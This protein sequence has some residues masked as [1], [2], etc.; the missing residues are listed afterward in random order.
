MCFILPFLLSFASPA[1]P[2][3]VVKPDLLNKT[4]MHLP[5]TY[6]SSQIDMTFLSNQT[7]DKLAD[8]IN[9]NTNVISSIAEL[10]QINSQLVMSEIQKGRCNPLQDNINSIWLSDPNFNIETV[11]HKKRVF[12]MISYVLFLGVIL[13]I[14]YSYFNILRHRNFPRQEEIIVWSIALIGTLVSIWLL[15]HIFSRLICSDYYLLQTLTKL[16]PG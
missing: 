11:I 2:D 16:V 12:D 1:E 7:A 5:I 8:V 10:T 6:T 13:W 14:F 3:P 4:S 9:Q 15:Y